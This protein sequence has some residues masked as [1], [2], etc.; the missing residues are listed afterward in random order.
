M[1]FR[2]SALRV[3]LEDVVLEEVTFER[4]VGDVRPLDLDGD[5]RDAIVHSGDGATRRSTRLGERDRVAPGHDECR[6]VGQVGGVTFSSG[7]P[8]PTRGPTLGSQRAR[9]SLSALCWTGLATWSS[10]PT[11]RQRSS[12]CFMALAVMATIG[13]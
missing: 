2:Q 13:R 7:A 5:E 6:P 10:M 1:T 9:A 3:S 8:T 12:S 4:P 11:S